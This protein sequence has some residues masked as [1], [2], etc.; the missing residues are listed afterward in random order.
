MSRESNSSSCWLLIHIL[1]LAEW[2]S[3]N[4]CLRYM[5]QKVLEGEGGIHLISLMNKSRL[6]VCDCVFFIVFVLLCLY[7]VFRFLCFDFYKFL[8]QIPHR[9]SCFL[10]TI[11]PASKH[12]TTNIQFAFGWVSSTQS[13]ILSKSAKLRYFSLT[14]FFFRKLLFQYLFSFSRSIFDKNLP[15]KNGGWSY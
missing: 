2:K 1:A 7:I 11:S 14:L 15:R 13:W 9:T 8:D 4:H 3:K 10:C 5:E 12:K 6:F